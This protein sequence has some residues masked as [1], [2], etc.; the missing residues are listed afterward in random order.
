MEALNWIKDNYYKVAEE[1]STYISCVESVYRNAFIQ[2]KST[3]RS[4][5]L[6]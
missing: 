3:P 6:E 1:G 4:F 5:I 2:I